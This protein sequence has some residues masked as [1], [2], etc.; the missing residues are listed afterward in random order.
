MLVPIIR[1]FIHLKRCKSLSS[2]VVYTKFYDACLAASNRR[3]NP[4]V[5]TFR[6]NEILTKTKLALRFNSVTFPVLPR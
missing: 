1:C 3:Y 5:C 4:K 2:Y 6:L